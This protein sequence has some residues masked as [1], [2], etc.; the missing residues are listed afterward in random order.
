MK[1]LFCYLGPDEG[2]PD[3][4]TLFRTMV[5]T[6][7]E[8]TFV[9][10]CLEPS[11]MT[12]WPCPENLEVITVPRGVSREWTRFRLSFAGLG[13]I[14]RERGADVVWAHNLGLYRRSGIPQVLSIHNAFMVVPWDQGRLHPARNP[15]RIAALRYFFRRSLDAADGVIVQTPVMA[16][17][18]QALWGGRGPVAIVSKA[19]AR[20]PEGAEPLPE[21]AARLVERGRDPAAFTFV[22]VAKPWPHKNHAVLVSA[23]ARLRDRGAKVRLVTT[24]TEDELARLAGEEARSLVASGHVVPVGQLPQRA[25]HALYEA[26]DACVMPSR[27]ESLSTAHLEAM[28]FERPQVAADL[29]YARELC[30][31]AATYASADDPAEWARRMVELVR[32]PALRAHLVEAGRRRLGELPQAWPELAR[33]LRAFL[34]SVARGAAS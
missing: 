18:V 32:D 3:L 14:A 23:L 21:A 10:V 8:D 6:F 12:S 26:G 31:P 17:R 20:G 24:V 5:A 30:G 1:I 16:E 34:G 29:A 22:Y 25:L 4:S 19:V 27:I 28:R 33:Q 7:P 15:V 2:H 9:A 13:R 11:V